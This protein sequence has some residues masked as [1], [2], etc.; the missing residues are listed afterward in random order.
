MADFS[1][2]HETKQVKSESGPGWTRQGFTVDVRNHKV[3]P[4]EVRVMVTVG[5]NYRVESETLDN[6]PTT[7]TAKDA[8]T[9]EFRGKADKDGA[10]KLA[11]TVY[12]SS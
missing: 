3:E 8:F 5:T 2:A 12:H 10:A 1:R 6:Q 9:L 11:Y 4:I 7:H